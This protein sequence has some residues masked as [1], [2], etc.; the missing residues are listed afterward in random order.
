MAVAHL[1]ALEKALGETQG[2]VQFVLISIQ[3]DK[4][5]RRQL[6]EFA[7]KNKI[8]QWQLVTG[9]ESRVRKIAETL[10]LG[11]S[12]RS[13]VEDL[14]Q[15]H[16]QSFTLLDERGRKMASIPSLNPNIEQGVALLKSLP[17]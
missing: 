5:K 4:D 3:G 15:L 12:D 2:Q 10:G 7:V 16:S 13:G 9:P 1:K 11:F 14:H 17:K 6:Q 8:E